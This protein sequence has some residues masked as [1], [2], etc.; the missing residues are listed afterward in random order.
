MRS[1]KG[2]V[3]GPTHNSVYIQ[4]YPVLRVGKRICLKKGN[5]KSLKKHIK[6]CSFL[7]C[8]REEEEAR[9]QSIFSS[10]TK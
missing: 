2:S 1:S 4:R 7:N 3:S 10:Y 8:K 5:K 6:F 9:T